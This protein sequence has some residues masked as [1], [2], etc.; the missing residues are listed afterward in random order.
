MGDDHTLAQ[1]LR[2]LDALYHSL[3]A[4]TSTLDLGQIL[5]TVLARIR[6]LVA[7]QALSLL[8]Y[9]RAHDELV[10]AATEMLREDAVLEPGVIDGVRMRLDQGIA[11]W[12]ASRRTAVRLEDA[13]ADPRHDSNVARHTGLVPRGMLCVPLVHR[14]RLLGVVQAINRLDGLPFTGDDER[15]VQALADHAAIAIAHAQL[16]RDVEQASLTD[17]LTGLGN[18]RCFH[19]VLPR[20]LEEA[21]PLSL[22]VLDLDRLKAV[23]DTH[24]HLVGSATIATV[25]RLI[26]AQLRP[27]DIA[28]RFGGDEFVVVLPLTDTGAALDVAERIRAAVAACPV[29][30]GFPVDIRDVTASLGVATAPHHATDP[31]GLFR[32]ADAAMYAVKRRL[33]NAV[34][35]ATD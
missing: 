31:D 5:N 6:A 14:D 19:R 13:S 30:H 26:A 21:L 29:P 32:A 25:G 28:A 9:D 1:Q 23:V 16:Y 8:L 27:G 24:G 11:G 12:V 33:R 2:E 18:T 4:I 7:P 20:L 10:F 22:L 34:G 15:L 3:R 17:D 35:I